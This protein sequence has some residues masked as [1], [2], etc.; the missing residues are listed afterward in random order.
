MI[1]HVLMGPALMNGGGIGLMGSMH[2]NGSGMMNG[3][4]TEHEH[5][6]PAEVG[7]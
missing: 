7:K 6:T 1:C 3:M 2:G 4:M 5:P